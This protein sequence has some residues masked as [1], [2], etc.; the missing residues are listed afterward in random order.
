M[1]AGRLLCSD[2]NGQVLTLLGAVLAGG[3]FACRS[4]A[5]NCFEALSSMAPSFEVA[6]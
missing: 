2:A 5:R 6:L 1:V 4:L 3:L